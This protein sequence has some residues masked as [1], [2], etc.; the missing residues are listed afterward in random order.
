MQYLIAENTRGKCTLIATNVPKITHRHLTHI[1]VENLGDRGVAV[2]VLESNL[3]RDQDGEITPETRTWL[4]QLVSSY[5]SHSSSESQQ[6]EE[7][8]QSKERRTESFGA[9]SVDNFL[10]TINRKR[11]TS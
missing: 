2:T 11:G 6:Q 4:Q 8:S 1:E 5:S 3:I 10:S 7:S 9:D